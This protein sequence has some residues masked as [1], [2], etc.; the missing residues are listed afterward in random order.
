MPELTPGR[1]HVVPCIASALLL[2]IALGEH[3][4]GYY[5]FLRWAVCATAVWT[6]VCIARAEAPSGLKGTLILICTA[7][8]LLFNPL[9]PIYLERSTWAIWDTLVA[10]VFIV[11]SFLRFP[12]RG[13]RGSQ[14]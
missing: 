14:G 12:V 8:A 10:V 2:I 6:V 5:T 9:T 4:Y 13:S 3:Q 1:T 7:I 11:L